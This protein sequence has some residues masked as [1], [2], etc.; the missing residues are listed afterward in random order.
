MTT[1]LGVRDKK[2]RVAV[3]AHQIVT[4]RKSWKGVMA[5]E[6]HLNNVWK[7]TCNS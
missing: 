1:D 2:V 5:I 6:V 4:R 7:G 3:Q